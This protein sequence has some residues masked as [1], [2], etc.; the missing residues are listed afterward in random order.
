MEEFIR[1]FLHLNFII[2]IRLM[3]SI[4]LLVMAVSF[5]QNGYSQSKIVFS[6]SLGALNSGGTPDLMIFDLASKETN[7]IFKGSVRGRGEYSASISPDKS[8]IIVNTYN[9]SGWKLGIADYNNG[10]IVE[11]KRFT[12]R[13]NYE[14]SAKWSHDGNYVAYQEFNW[15]T[16]D[17]EIFIVDKFG[18]NPKQ[19]TKSAGGDRTPV[20]S[21]DDQ[22]IIFTSG[23]VNAY[24]IYLKTFV[25]GNIVNLSNNPFSN[26]FAP[27]TS[28]KENSI[29]F[30]SDREGSVNLYLMNYEERG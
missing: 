7:L 15:N 10:E 23:R 8:K 26:D 4:F 12:S 22:A 28:T 17:T 2:L 19:I 24:D 13:T 25:N 16:G 1:I 9:F 27:S 20:W 29:A 6:R 30:L 14:Y 5:L 3:R 11:F 21:R 18:E